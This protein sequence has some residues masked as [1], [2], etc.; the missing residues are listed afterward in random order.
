MGVCGYHKYK[1]KR[2]FEMSDGVR[3]LLIVKRTLLIKKVLDMHANRVF[4]MPQTI[5]RMG[6]GDIIERT[7]P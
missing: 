3:L 2:N 5:Y 7:P 1:E 6:R 4:G